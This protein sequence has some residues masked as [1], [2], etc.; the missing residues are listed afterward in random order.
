[1]QTLSYSQLNSSIIHPK[2]NYLLHQY[3]I[4]HLNFIKFCLTIKTTYY[5]LFYLKN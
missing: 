4:L 1:M 2:F 3:I 5:L